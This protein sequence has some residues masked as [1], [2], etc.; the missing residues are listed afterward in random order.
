MAALASETLL[1]DVTT[2][3]MARSEETV[4][5]ML[6]MSNAEKVTNI[7]ITFQVDRDILTAAGFEARSGFRALSSDSGIVWT[8]L[9]DNM[10]QGELLLVYLTGNNGFTSQSSAD[11][12]DLLFNAN[13][14]GDATLEIL[15]ITAAMIGEDGKSKYA[16]VGYTNQSATTVITTYS[17]YDINCDGVVDQLDLS[18]AQIVYWSAEDD[19][20]WASAKS[21]DVIGD[22]V[23]DMLDL[24]LIYANFTK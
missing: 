5:Y 10:W 7:N 12:L 4:S 3:P 11:V 18:D 9:A 23:V 13:T 2:D 21:A 19:A 20:N 8:Q 24:L 1:F 15:S 22:G 16:V 6:S 14:L 17:Q